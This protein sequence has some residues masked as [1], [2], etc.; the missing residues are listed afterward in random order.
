MDI[1]E[2]D[3]WKQKNSL[4]FLGFFNFKSAK[5][6]SFS[7]KFRPSLL[8]NFGNLLDMYMYSSTPVPVQQLAKL[9]V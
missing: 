6:F 4:D 3:S 8:K 1:P 2:K 7:G 5:F 9:K